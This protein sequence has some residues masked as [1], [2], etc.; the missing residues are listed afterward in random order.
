MRHAAGR[1]GMR[2]APPLPPW[3]S[4]GGWTLV[5]LVSKPPRPQVDPSEVRA[6]QNRPSR[7]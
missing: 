7:R 4:S 6:G 2:M 5:K 3:A 1:A